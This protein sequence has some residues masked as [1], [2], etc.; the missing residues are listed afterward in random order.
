MY[1]LP[2]RMVQF[3]HHLPMILI[4]LTTC[5]HSSPQLPIMGKHVKGLGNVLTK[6]T[7]YR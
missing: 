7:K 5:L 6:M 4:Q 3:H 2:I 1:E